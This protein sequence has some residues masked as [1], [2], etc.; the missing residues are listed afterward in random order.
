MN[1]GKYNRDQDEAT[2]IIQPKGQDDRSSA[3]QRQALPSDV[4]R[5]LVME[6][7]AARRGK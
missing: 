7:A 2:G 3:Q 1:D 5:K 4:A 6:A